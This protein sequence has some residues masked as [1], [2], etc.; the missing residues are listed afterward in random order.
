MK[1]AIMQPY[2]FPYIGYWQLLN[3]VDKYVIYDDVNYIKGGW[4]NRNKIL[5]NRKAE[6]INLQTYKA[7]P[8]KRINEIETLGNDVY[9]NKLLKKIESAYI[10]SPFFEDVFPIIIKII[11]QNERNLSKYLTFSI[12]EVC[13]YL[14]ID[15]QIMLSSDI[16]KNNAL[17]SQK[18]VIEICKLLKAEQYINPIGGIELYSKQDFAL[19]GIQLNFLKSNDIVYQQF[20]NE[21]VQNLSIIDVMM[22]NSKEDIARLLL[23]YDLS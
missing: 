6:L 18:R 1:V 4:I 21:F 11:N 5:L 16:S 23:K 12:R 2:F 22:F 9:N 20:K 8:N 10:K 15:T 13:K 3:A 14:N 19:Q 7:S 17:R